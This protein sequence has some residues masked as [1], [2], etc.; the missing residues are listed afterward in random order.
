MVVLFPPQEEP[1]NV[2]DGDHSPQHVYPFYP[3]PGEIDR[4]RAV[5]S[6]NVDT[7]VE[8]NE[9]I[10]NERFEKQMRKVLS[11]RTNPLPVRILSSE[12]LNF[13]FL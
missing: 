11:P 3:G 13:C 12:T 1:S 6:R 8:D 5:L 7:W 10:I 4:Y 9:K 2:R